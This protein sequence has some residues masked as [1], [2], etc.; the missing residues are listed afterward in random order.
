MHDVPPAGMEAALTLVVYYADMVEQRKKRPTDDLTS[1]L[2]A[3][4]ID[5]DRLTDE[6]IIAFLFLMVVAGNETTT[7][8]LGQRAVPPDPAPRAARPG[9]RRPAQR[10]TSWCRGSRRRCATTPPA[11]WSPGTCSQDVELH[12]NV[13]PAGLQ[14]AARARLGQPRRPGLHRPGPL[15]HLPRQGRG[16]PAAQLRRRP[17]LLPRRQ[18]GP[19][20]GADRAARAG[21]P[22]ARRSRS[23]TTRA[24]R[25]HSVNVR[26]FARVPVADGGALMGK[27]AQPDRR[28]GGRHRRVVRASAPPPRWRSPRPATRSRSAPA[29]STSARRS[30]PQIRA[31]GRRGGR[32]RAR[33]HRRRV[34]RRRSPTA[35]T[36]DLG[37]IEVVV[38]NAGSVAP[39][40]STRST[41]SGS[42]ARST[43]TSLGAH[44]LV[45]AFVPGHGRAAARR[46]RLR[47][48]R[49]RGAGPAVH[50]VVRRRQVGP[51]GHGARAADGARGHRRPRLDRAARPDL[52]RD[53]HR[54]GRRATR[55][56]CSTSGCGSA[57]PATR[58]S[59]SRRAIADAI[60]SVVTAPRG[61]H[62]N[63]I[64]VTPEAPLEDR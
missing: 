47:L 17:A 4:E 23:T 15:R 16:R 43:S 10:T 18:P 55:P 25:V 62:L 57:W 48:L 52:E 19:A 14:A 21:P 33:R 41:P 44:R 30:R 60:T 46:R 50:V 31:D 51:R 53:G 1:A 24:V 61:V 7:K 5:G 64:E 56:S 6:E 59:S 27:Y 34:G 40:T 26:G 12:G 32:P 42:R 29:A 2:L 37:D 8:L 3:A 20:R 35:V 39:G 22:G 13:A 36:A 58:T 63:L 28:P 38:T 45:R 54:L 9:L 49:R 11:R